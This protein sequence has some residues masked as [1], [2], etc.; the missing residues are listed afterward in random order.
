MVGKLPKHVAEIFNIYDDGRYET[1]TCWR[2]I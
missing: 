2:K 1:E